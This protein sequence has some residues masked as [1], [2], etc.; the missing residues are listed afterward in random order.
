[1]L[2]QYASKKAYMHVV[3]IAYMPFLFY[4]LFLPYYQFSALT[5]K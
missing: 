3:K 1:M 5:S 2:I 4:T